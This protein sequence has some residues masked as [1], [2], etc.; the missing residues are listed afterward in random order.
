MDSKIVH[1]LYINRVS[2]FKATLEQAEKLCTA[3]GSKGKSKV[4][5]M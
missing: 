3:L 5:I 4:K 2:C 1:D